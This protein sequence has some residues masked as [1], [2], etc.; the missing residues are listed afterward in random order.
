[1]AWATKE[2]SC[3][4]RNMKSSLTLNHCIAPDHLLADQG[5][6]RALAAISCCFYVNASG[7]I[8]D[9]VT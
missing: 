3:N 4:F 6:I 7:Q 5:G 8:E 9:S 1:M 2:L